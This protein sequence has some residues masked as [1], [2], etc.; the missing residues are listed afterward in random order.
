MESLT[1]PGTLDSLKAI[2][3]YVEAAASASKLDARRAYR[4]S[5]AID[6][7]ATNIITHGYNESGSSGQIEVHAVQ[8]AE[9][10][11]ITIED[12]SPAFDPFSRGEPAGLD[13]PLEERN[14]GGLGIFLAI[15]NVDEFRY[16]YVDGQNRNIFVVST[17]TA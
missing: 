14:I 10:L 17:S 8:T 9:G 3:D 13:A 5:L 16:E 6:E 1:L 15:K 11:E 7:I 12:S 4:L 2:R